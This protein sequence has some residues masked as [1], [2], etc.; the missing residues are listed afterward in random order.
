MKKTILT[1]TSLVLITL[2]ASAQLSNGL[3]AH[4]MLDG[5]GADSS[6]NG[7]HGT[8]MGATS[9]ANLKNQSNKAM[10]FSS[11]SDYID[12]PN[13]AALHPTSGI[14]VA[15]WVYINAFNPTSPNASDIIKKGYDDNATGCY[16][17]RY[18]GGS[19]KAYF[20]IRFSDGTTSAP[21]STST[22]STGQWYHLLGSYDGSTMKMYVNGTLEASEAVSKTMTSN[23]DQLRIGRNIDV[24]WPYP[25]NGKIDDVRIYNRALKESEIDQLYGILSSVKNINNTSSISIYPNPSNGIFT[26]NIAENNTKTIIMDATGKLVYSQNM[27]V[28]EEYSINLSNLK[29]GIYFIKFTSNTGVKTKKIIIE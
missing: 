11:T 16:L 2:T 24:S 20:R 26:I 6:G 12:V 23:T 1:L 22:L 5:N 28:A 17:L 27:Q 7:H 9:T 3:I 25:V 4:Y 18:S 13:S 29:P 10:Q 21:L 8:V 19:K 14:T 15:A